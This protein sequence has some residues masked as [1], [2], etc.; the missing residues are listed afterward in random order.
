[1]TDGRVSVWTLLNVYDNSKHRLSQSVFIYIWH[2]LLYDK[3]SLI[4][5]WVNYNGKCDMLRLRRW[6]ENHFE[7]AGGIYLDEHTPVLQDRQR[8][9]SHEM[10]SSAR[11]LGS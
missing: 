2:S 7:Y 8:R 11:T 1:M 5:F 9:L 3:Y 10:S 4:F 6:A